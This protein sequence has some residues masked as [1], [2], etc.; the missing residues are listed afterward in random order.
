MNMAAPAPLA[1]DNQAL[2][3]EQALLGAILMDTSA[4]EKARSIVEASDFSEE[5]HAKI[6]E[7]MCHQQ[8]EG[9]V[10]TA[11]LVRM[12]TGNADLGGVTITEY[13]TKLYENAS[14][15]AN[16]GQYAKAIKRASL[17]RKMAAA[18]ADLLERARV[19]S[20]I[21]DPAEVASDTID[22]LD[23]VASAS[24]PDSLRRVSLGEAA[25]EAIDAAWDARSGKVVRGAPYGIPSLDRKTMGM[26]PGQLIIVAARPGMGK[27]TAG[28]A[29][30]LNSAKVG[31]GVFFFSLEM[32]AKEL[33]ERALAAMCY[34]PQREMITYRGIAEGSSLSEEAFSRLKS[35]A[36][37]YSKLPFIIEQEAG[38]TVSQIAARARRAKAQM[39][40]KGQKLSVLVVDHIGLLRASTRYAGNKVQEVTEI[41]GALK[42]LAKELGVAVVALSQL[43]R[44]VEKRNGNDKRPQLSDLRDS[45][46]IEQDA[47]MVMALYR[48]AYYLERKPNLSEEET[49]R[50]RESLDVMEVEILK[51]RQGP[52]GRIRLYCNISCNAIAELHQ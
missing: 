48:E 30:A 40:Q 45:G 26:R 47:D 12:V 4:L 15:V 13:L 17:F 32:V 29:F 52:T 44:E 51:Q 24:M 38:L 42:V 2:D 43:S 11:G 23:G 25:V 19:A 22:I 7:A 1:S 33:G 36:E 31:H 3:A 28:V 6:F 5:V 46:S 34:S 35:A 41:T 39:A 27:T 14:S 18:G 9:G 37:R 49:L 16:A 20:V 8:D 10:I 50:L 21:D